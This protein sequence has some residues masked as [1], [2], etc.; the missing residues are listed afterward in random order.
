MCYCVGLV[1]LHDLSNEVPYHI[2]GS[3]K[4]GGCHPEM[5]TLVTENKS[6]KK[7]FQSI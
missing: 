7:V 3:P 2:K 1:A 6:K 4:S 5:I